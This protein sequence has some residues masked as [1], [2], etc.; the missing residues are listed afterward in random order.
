MR[1]WRESGQFS[2]HFQGLIP[3]PE[4]NSPKSPKIV[5]LKIPDLGQGVKGI[6]GGP[7]IV[8]TLGEVALN[9]AK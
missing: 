2:A 1:F 8:G 6:I 5:R 7:G 9:M 4:K 3:N